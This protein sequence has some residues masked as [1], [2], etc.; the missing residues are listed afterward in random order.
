M[1]NLLHLNWA[2]MGLGEIANEFAQSLNQVHEIYAAASRNP[3]RAYNFAKKHHIK[4][5]YASYEELLSDENVD[6]VYIATVNS[7]HYQNIMQCLQHNKHVL[8]EKAI[9]HNKHDMKKAYA[10][11]KKKNVFLGEAM[12]I[13]YM[14]LYKK[15]KEMITQGKLGK[16]KMIRADFGSLKDPDPANRFF[17][18]ELG[19]GAL[20][21]IGTYALSFVQYFLSRPATELNYVISKFQTGGDE[22][23]S[24][25][26]KNDED[27]IGNVHL[28]F[29]AKLPKQGIIAGEKGYITVDNYPRAN[30]A[31]LV[32]PNGE[33]ETIVA[34]KTEQAMV[35]EIQGVEKAIASQ[36]YA[37]GSIETPLTSSR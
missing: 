8:C 4:N 28:T 27:E 5:I 31:I 36:N 10:F 23:W 11:A 21:D 25:H 24:I 34:G 3:E 15:I 18:K 9:W 13:Y 30:T 2:I 35:Y 14:P 29:R 33:K 26:V 17:S 37:L 22:T 19:G 20:L 16:L 1:K 32:Y 6:I 12:T 7:Q